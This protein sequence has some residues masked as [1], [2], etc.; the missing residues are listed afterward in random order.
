MER[1][2]HK[3]KSFR[4]ADLW[5]LAQYREMTPDERIAAARVLQRSVYGK[6]LPDVRA[7]WKQ[8]SK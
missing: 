6:D 2:V 1:V 5:T 3:S 4:E 7:T 8:T